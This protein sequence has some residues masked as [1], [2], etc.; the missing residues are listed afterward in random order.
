MSTL[1]ESAAQLDAKRAADLAATDADMG[2]E[3]VPQEA[4][5]TELQVQ[6]Q[7]YIGGLPS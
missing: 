2:I 4:S 1:L 6:F 7:G 5:E 3:Q